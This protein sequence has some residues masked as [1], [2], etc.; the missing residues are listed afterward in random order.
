[1][2]KHRLTHALAAAALAC[3]V[4]G[5]SA[6]ADHGQGRGQ[7]FK[8]SGELTAAP[9]PN[10][11]SVSVQVEGGNRPALRALIGSSQNQVFTLGSGTEILICSHGVPHVRTTADLQQGDSQLAAVVAA[12]A[13]PNGGLPL[14]L[15]VGNVAGPQSGGHIALHV[16]SGNWKAL[17]AMLGQPLDQSFTYD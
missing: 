17:Q 10:A 7:V 11:G 8:F 12:T 1:M 6:A 14:W 16:T 3:A 9:G 15:F 4:L 2:V 13:A 5:G